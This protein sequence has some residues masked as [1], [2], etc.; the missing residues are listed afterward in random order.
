MGLTAGES[1]VSVGPATPIVPNV[2]LEFDPGLSRP[3]LN[4]KFPLINYA[5]DVEIF[6]LRSSL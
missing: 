6:Q 4:S 3:K 2:L 5:F 1:S